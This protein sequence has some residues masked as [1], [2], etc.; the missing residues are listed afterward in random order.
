V[1]EIRRGLLV[2]VPKC[3]WV[4]PQDVALLPE[5]DC[6]PHAVAAGYYLDSDGQQIG[7]CSDY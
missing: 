1:D 7:R 3:R 5:L 6:Q 2:L 4:L